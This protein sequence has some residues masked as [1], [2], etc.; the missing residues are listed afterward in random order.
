[1]TLGHGHGHGGPDAMG[2]ALHDFSSNGNACGPCPEA[3]AAVQAADATRYPDPS[4]QRLRAALASFHG[5]APDR[6]VVA[7]SGS[8]W[9]QRMTVL[10]K[11]Q[12]G[13]SAF[14]PEEAYGDYA[15]AAQSHGLARATGW[16]VADLVWT[17]EPSSPRGGTDGVLA[18]GVGAGAGDSVGR[19]V[20]V[21]DLAYEPLRLF[22]APSRP[23]HELDGLWQLWSPNKALGL[24]GVRAAFAIAPRGATEAARALDQLAPSWVVGA[25]GVALL[26]A[27]CQPEVQAWVQR[28]HETLRLWG[29]AWTRRC[30]ALGWAWT[31]GDANFGVAHLG[32]EGEALMR[33]LQ[34]LRA[35]GIKLRLTDSLGL[36]NHV[37][38]AILPPASQDALLTAWQL[39]KRH[40][41]ACA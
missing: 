28:S 3:H 41:E 9:I 25:H 29:A 14:C 12:G 21:M 19:Q 23:A 22:G 18:Q 30:Q 40:E 39:W 37:R 2:A 10:V 33:C 1:M 20:V 6:I 35:Q 5:V 27:W 16:Q 32:L 13:Q 31:A 11:H 15:H 8:E 17:C 24:T 4:Y 7:G 34:F 36:A 38:V 26:Q